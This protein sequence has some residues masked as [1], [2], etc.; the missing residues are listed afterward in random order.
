[1]DNFSEQ[2]VTRNTTT[3][4]IVKRV[5]VM[6]AAVLLASFFMWLAMNGM[7]YMVMLAFV[8]LGGGIWL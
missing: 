6:I 4:D 3:A 1:M 5:L 2:L 7:F 8:A